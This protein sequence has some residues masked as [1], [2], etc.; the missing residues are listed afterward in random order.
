MPKTALDLSGRVF[1]RLT[2]LE[3]AEKIHRPRSTGY[4]YRY[5]CRCQCGNLHVAEARALKEGTIRSC[6]CWSR[7]SIGSNYTVSDHMIDADF[8]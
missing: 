6:G 5:R 1:G 7:V 4:Y 8:D 2:V 3:L